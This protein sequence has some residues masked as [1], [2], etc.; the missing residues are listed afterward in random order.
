MKIRVGAR[1]S[2]LSI[3]QMDIVLQA[4]KQKR[5]DLTFEK[6]IMKTKGD[7]ILNRSLK[8]IGGKGLFVGEF[9]EALKEGIIDIAI[10]SGKDLP[11][12]SSSCFAFSVMKRGAPYDVLIKNKDQVQVIGTSSPRREVLL[13]KLMP[14]AQVKMLRGNINT[15]IEKLRSGEYDAIILAQAGLERLQPSL[16]GLEVMPLDPEVFVPASCQ[17]ILTIEY[18]KDSPFQEIF[19]CIHDEETYQAFM[20]ERQVMQGLQA[21]CHDAVGAY[22]TMEKGERMIRSFYHQS[23][24]YYEKADQLP[25][26][27][28]KLKE[29]AHGD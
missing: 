25:L 7:L 5:P 24:I 3:A 11:A 2:Q 29:H 13:H 20:L 6:V 21:S 15:R 19:S 28:Q 26:L 27:I 12:L 1:G 9:E 14:N 4:L 8:E 23:P 22:S 18:L 16:A 10:H 17:G